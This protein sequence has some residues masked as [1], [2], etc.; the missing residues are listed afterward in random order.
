MLEKVDW[1]WMDGEF[2]RWDEAQV[3][4]LTHSLHY[5]YAAFEGIRCYPQKG[6]G[7]AIFR[8]TDHIKRLYNSAHI[9]ALEIPYKKE[10]ISEACRELVRKNGLAEGG[11]YI[12]PLVYM[13]YGSM[14]LGALDNPTNVCI[15]AWR[16]GAYLGDEGV[17]SG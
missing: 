1:I 16:W 17:K 14:G 15:A 13:G 9:L 10:E 3:H 4:V 8:L 2:V 11:C 5:G 12:R 7:G 6:G